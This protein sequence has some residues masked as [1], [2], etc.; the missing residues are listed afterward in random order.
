MLIQL[1]CAT[2]IPPG[3]W[4]AEGERAIVTA[5]ELLTPKRK[6]HTEDDEEDDGPQMSG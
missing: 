1:A 3:V 4:A 5:V 6:G 2:G